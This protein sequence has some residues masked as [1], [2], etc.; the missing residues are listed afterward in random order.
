MNIN[1]I[2]IKFNRK[3]NPNKE[4]VDLLIKRLEYNEKTF[5]KPYCP[6]SLLKTDEM[7][8][9]CKQSEKD[10]EEKG[11]CHCWLFIK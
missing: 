10:I 6:C 2:L 3:L 9:P 4:M 11:H 8:C 5:G 7:A 1:E